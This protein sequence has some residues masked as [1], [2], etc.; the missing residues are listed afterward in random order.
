[1]RSAPQSRPSV[2][3][4]AASWVIAFGSSSDL[5]LH[6]EHG[7]PVAYAAAEERV[8][9]LPIDHIGLLVAYARAGW[10]KGVVRAVRSVARLRDGA[11]S[12]VL[13]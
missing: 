1:M 4:V 3:G 9:R 2:P 6:R 11:F 5:S 7:A 10:M 13:A 12:V 8:V